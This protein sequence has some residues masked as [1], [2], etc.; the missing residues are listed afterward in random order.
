MKYAALCRLN[1]LQQSLLSQ[2]VLEKVHVILSRTFCE[3]CLKHSS[4]WTPVQAA[5]ICRASR[6][7]EIVDGRDCSDCHCGCP[8]P[9]DQRLSLFCVCAA[10][11]LLET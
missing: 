5:G 9:G 4:E 3:L 2:H 10:E 7:E 6:E 8:A 11:V 1:N